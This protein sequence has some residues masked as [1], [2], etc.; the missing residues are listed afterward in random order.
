MRFFLYEIVARLV[1]LYLFL[2][3]IPR[4]RNG[5]RERK[6][7]LFNSDL[8]D[9]WSHGIVERDAAPIRYWITIALQIFAMI[10]CFFVVIF[11]WHQAS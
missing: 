11:G 7:A 1:A 4:L 5:F 2:D 3:S 10:G 9:W 6:I 8:L